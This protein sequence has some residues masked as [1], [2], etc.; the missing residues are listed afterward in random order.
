VITYGWDGGIAVG[1]L[2]PEYVL[3]YPAADTKAGVGLVLAEFASF[4]EEEKDP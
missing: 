3:A 1:N 4:F 2:L